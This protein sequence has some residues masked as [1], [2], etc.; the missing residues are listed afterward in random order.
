MNSVCIVGNSCRDIEVRYVKS[1]LAVATVTVAVED[2]KKGGEKD[3]SFVECT[4]WGRT[5]EIA[6][7]YLRKGDKVGISGRLLQ[8]NWD[9]DGQKHSKLT[10]VCEKMMLL[11]QKPRQEAGPANDYPSDEETAF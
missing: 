2:R 6:A 7:E 4:L 5:A 11:S 9:K 3:T 1:D 8:K 10:V